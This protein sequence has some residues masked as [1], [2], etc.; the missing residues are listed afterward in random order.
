MRPSVAAG[1]RNW[2]PTNIQHRAGR[3]VEMC[4]CG[5]S[6]N[7]RRYPG[8]GGRKIGFVGSIGFRHGVA[9]S[10]HKGVK[11]MPCLARFCR[12]TRRQKSSPE[13]RR[14]KPRPQDAAGVVRTDGGDRDSSGI[15]AITPP[16]WH[17]ATAVAA[18]HIPSSA[19]EG[20]FP[21]IVRVSRQTL[22]GN[23]QRPLTGLLNRSQRSP[24][25]RPTEEGVGRI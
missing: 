6:S 11:P 8:R 4:T 10:L 18:R 3:V 16:P 15:T 24:L 22:A 14:G 23:G 7:L 1:S 20:S 9:W 19:E 2:L 17:C 21:A 25:S 5:R 13:A 12:E